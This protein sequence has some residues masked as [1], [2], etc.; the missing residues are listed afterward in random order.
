MSQ[1]NNYIQSFIS[2]NPNME[3]KDQFRTAQTE[4]TKIKNNPEKIS[5][6]ISEF[7]LKASKIEAKKRQFWAGYRKNISSTKTSLNKPD[8][9]EKPSEA[10]L[11]EKSSTSQVFRI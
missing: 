10:F 6:Q 3:K 11:G 7:K 8:E 1:Y 4:W 2:A 5:E 9:V